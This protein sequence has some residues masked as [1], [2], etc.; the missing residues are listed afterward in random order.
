[1][2]N[3]YD[4]RDDPF[5][6]CDFTGNSGCPGVSPPFDYVPASEADYREQLAALAD[7][8][9]T[10]LHAP[11]LILV[12]EAEDQDICTV[13]GGALGC[14]DT[15]NADG[16][17]DTLQELAL[18]IAAAGGPAYAAAYDRTGADARG[19][20]AAFLY[21]TD[22]LSLAA[23]TAADPLLGSAPD[24]AVPVGG[25]AGQRRRAEP[26]GAQRGAAGRRGHLDRQGRQ[27]RLH[28][29]PAAGQVHRGGGARRDASGSPL[30]ALSNHYSSGPD[31]RVGQRREQAAYGAAIVTAIEAADATR[32]GGLRRGPERL[33]PPGRPDRDRREPD[34]VGPARPALRGGP[35]QP[36]GRPGGR[37]AVVGVLVQLRGAGADAGP[38][39]RQRRAARRP[40]ADAGGAHQRRLAG[41]VHA[42]TGHAVPA[43]TTRRWP[44]SAP[45]RR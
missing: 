31:S 43:T 45:G 33:P 16:A 5:D 35:A 17:P 30:C 11:D 39:V 42:A 27:Q 18:A 7:Q 37:R 14:G 10:D 29:R 9:V 44:G 21:R 4:Y 32:P 41:G 40:G 2:E 24:R 15:N 3:L 25:A 34:P 38:P 12:Q 1:M 26:E 22:R 36:V 8:I 28:P 13:S 19:I 6:G 20:T 23:A